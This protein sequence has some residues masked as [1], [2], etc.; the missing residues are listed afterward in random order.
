MCRRIEANPKQID[1]IIKIALPKTKREVQRLT[2]RVVALNGFISRSKDKCFPLYETFRG[3]KKFEWSEECEKVFK[4]LKH[5]L[6]TPTVLVKPIEGELCSSTSWYP[7]RLWVVLIK[8]ERSEQKPILCQKKLDREKWYPL[9]KKLALVG[10][11]T[12]NVFPVARN[13]NPHHLP[14][15]DIF[16]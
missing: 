8:E 6:T 12:E 7:Q 9:M 4:Q 5:Y 15:A 14:I 1:A 3:N 11:K 10:S 2:G 16:A 13:R